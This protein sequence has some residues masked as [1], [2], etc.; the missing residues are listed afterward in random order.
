M[1][2]TLCGTGAGPFTAQ[3]A[4]SGY[5]LQSDGHTLMLDC[6]PGSVR[7]AMAAGIELRDVEA[8]FLSHIHEDHCLDLGAFTM[9]A[10]YG[11]FERLP[12]VYVPPGGRDV[13][14]KLMT[15]H[16]ST[17]TLPPLEIVEVESGDERE[18]CG[19]LV[20]SEET[21]HAADL[22]AFSRRFES[23]GRSFVFSGDTRPNPELMMVLAR[24]ADVLLHESYTYAALDRY[25]ST[26]TEERRKRLLAR[27]P[28]THSD[29][30][31]VAQIAED[32]GVKRL[33]L[34]HILP[35]EVESEMVEVASAIYKGDLIIGRDGMALEI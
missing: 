32:A 34:T 15:M 26:G 20:C 6:G 10:M 1:K 28:T 2:L 7:N 22:R 8:I 24:D 11:R 23:K 31:E 18:V 30:R 13:V 27:L 35:T 9:Q 12:V 33:V 16:R 14:T 4:S 25:A 19:F 3:R 29:L 17:A 5:I 21:Q